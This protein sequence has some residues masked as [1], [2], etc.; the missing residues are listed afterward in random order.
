MRS[1]LKNIRK[2]LQIAGYYFP[3]TWY[4]ILFLAGCW[5]GYQWLVNTPPIPGSAYDD[6]FY[7]L[8]QIAIW[9]LVVIIVTGFISVLIPYFLFK[10]KLRKN[11]IDFRIETKTEKENLTGAKRKKKYSFSDTAEI[12]QTVQ[13]YIHPILQPFL[14]FIKIRLQYDHFQFSEKFSLIEQTKI[15]LFNYTIDGVYHWSLP[16]IKEY[17]IEKLVIYFEDFFQFFSL[18]A[19]MNTQSRFHTHPTSLSRKMINAMP[20]KTEENNIRINELK[21]LEGEFLNYKNFEDHD[22]VRRIVWK[23]YARNKQLV[24]R[25]PEIVDPY[26][27]HIYLYASFFSS[28]NEQGN[29]MIEIPFLNYYKTQVWTIFQQLTKQGLEVRFVPDQETDTANFSDGIQQI[30]Y[31]IS[32]SKWQ[33]EKDL[34]T[35]IQPSE[36]S[37]VVISSLSNAEDVQ[38]L[39]ERYGHEISFVFISLTEI[40][41]KQYLTDWIQWVFVQ[42]EKDDLAVYKTN[43]RLSG[44]RSKIVKNE[45]KL[46]KLLQSYEKAVEV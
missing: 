21:K 40:L 45:K 14:G 9:F 31:N 12:K 17:K 4:L 18:T 43:W 36:A 28:F 23:I 29:E 46:K 8:L 5:I 24:V 7:L 44:L 26:A 33:K 32:I 15:K 22:D 34:K 19:L 27:S 16:E 37:V 10:W 35:Y 25:I 11:G 1:H 41:E 42:E 20:R 13:L 30:K 6:I 38:E 2:Q 3:F 39:L